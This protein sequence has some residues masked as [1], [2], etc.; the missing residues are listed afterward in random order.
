MEK[1]PKQIDCLKIAIT[2]QNDNSS[3]QID[4]PSNKNNTNMEFN[5][6]KKARLD[7]QHVRKDHRKRISFSIDM[8]NL[9]LHVR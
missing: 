7:E 6:T 8:R 4:R 3:D 5:A 9:K 2:K 1:K